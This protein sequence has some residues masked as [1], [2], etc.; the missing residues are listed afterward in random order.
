MKNFSE[1]PGLPEEL[2]SKL[3]RSS[4]RRL[5]ELYRDKPWSIMVHHFQPQDRRHNHVIKIYQHV[6]GSLMSSGSVTISVT[7]AGPTGL[8]IASARSAT[9]LN[10][11][12]GPTTMSSTS[13][14]LALSTQTKSVT[15]ISLSVSLTTLA[16]HSRVSWV[17]HL[18]SFLVS[19]RGQWLRKLLNDKIVK[20][21]IQEWRNFAV[22][23]V[24]KYLFIQQL[25]F[26]RWK[27]RRIHEGEKPFKCFH[28]KKLKK[29]HMT[30]HIFENHLQYVFSMI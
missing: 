22:K 16:P 25:F 12:M 18:A 15:S 8:S 9:A 11:S 19:E 20:S 3:C 24:K 14:R 13:S 4:G 28:C 5:R 21:E 6:Y 23:Y 7:T 2:A 30:T 27:I 26:N 1:L 10:K 17:W 29:N